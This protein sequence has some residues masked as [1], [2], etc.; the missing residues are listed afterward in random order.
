MTDP[1]AF[2]HVEDRLVHK[3]YVWD[4]VVGTFE[5]PDGQ[6][7]ERDVVRSPGAVGVV[8]LIDRPGDDPLV[9]L[10]AQY[11]ASFDRVVVEVPAG[12]CDVDGEPAADTARRE[13]AEEVGL[14]AQHVEPLFDM[15]ASPG[16]TDQVLSLFV[17]TGCER[18]SREAHG[19]EE[20]HA[21]VIELP[22]PEAVSWI[23]SGRIRDAKSVIGLLLVERTWRAGLR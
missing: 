2:R 23:A 22:L 10:V 8:P 5:G 7:F 3:G 18:V 1:P 13:L 12:M 11:R 17:A 14:S 15:I 6:R 4:L 16:M 9:V 19:V 21:E 20:E